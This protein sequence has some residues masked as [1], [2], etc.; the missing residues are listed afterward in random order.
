MGMRRKGREIAIKVLYSL[1][2]DESEE[3][4]DLY[5]IKLEEM[6]ENEDFNNQNKIFEFASNLVE[7]TVENKDEIDL[8]IQHHSKN[9]SFDQI[10]HLDKSILRVAVFEL[11]F[12][13]TAPPII[14]NEAIEITKKYCT[15]NSG[16]FVNG[17][18]NAI[19]KE[20]A[21]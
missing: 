17:I 14:M 3:T 6:T 2:Y 21:E 18:L 13:D 20:N 9:W 8:K 4:I 5:K 7:G 1:E 10:A 19:S 16:K 11:L 15:D 12:T